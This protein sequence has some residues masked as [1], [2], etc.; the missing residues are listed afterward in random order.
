MEHHELLKVL[1]RIIVKKGNFIL[2]SGRNSSYYLDMR[3]AYA[4]P[5]IINALADS[6]WKVTSREANCIAGYGIGGIPLATVIASRY[7]LKLCM[8]REKPKT[9]G[10]H[11]QIDGYIPS[12][13]DNLL[14]IDDVYSTGSTFNDA[15]EVL[16]K[17]GIKINECAVIV[18]RNS[19]PEHAVNYVYNGKD[20]GISED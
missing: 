12:A 19:N 9:Y 15:I 3:A 10:A 6:L 14:L 5:E 18:L 8:L 7:N 4:Y 16:N 2:R 20:F 13:D 1:K 17:V 11:K